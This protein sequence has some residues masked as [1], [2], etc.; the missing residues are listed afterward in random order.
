M[1]KNNRP[2]PD[3]SLNNQGVSRQDIAP[4]EED[5]YTEDEMATRI[6][7][8][9]DIVFKYVFGAEESTEILKSFVNAVL[10][11]SGFPE[12]ETLSISNP[13]NIKTYIDDKPSIIDTRATDNKGDKYN[14]EVQVR[15]QA[16]FQERSLYYW[17][18]AYADQLTEGREFGFL[19]RVTSISLLNFRLFPDHIPFHSCFML[20]ENENTEYALSLDCIMHYLELPKFDGKPESEVRRWLYFLEHI[21]EE[22]DTLK[23]LLEKNTLFKA[24]ERRYKY[25]LSDEK[26]RAAYQARSMFLHD[27]ASFIANA[28]R[29][30]LAEGRAEGMKR[31]KEEGRAAGREEGRKEGIGQGRHQQAVLT[32]MELKDMGLSVEQIIDATGL[33]EEEIRGL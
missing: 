12:I 6:P 11:D 30:G 32:A 29:E 14:V 25:F 31:G 13:F 26:A 22:D 28:R 3:H 15:T 1:K 7:A 8:I 2:Q 24:A 19:N 23:V 27:Q 33:A 17:A 16:D 4:E 21:D 20:R 10:K 9:S 5:A 18:K